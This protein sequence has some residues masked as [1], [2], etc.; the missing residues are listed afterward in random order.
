MEEPMNEATERFRTFLK[1]NGFYIVLV[2]CLLAIGV[3]IALIAIP[4]DREQ[5]ADATPDPEPVV[6]VGQSNDER[7]SEV[8]NKPKTTETPKLTPPPLAAITPIPTAEPTATPAARQNTASKAAPPVDGE[9]IFSYAVDK[10]IYSVTLDQWTTHPAIDIKAK[11]GTPVKC[12]FSGTVESVKKDDALGFSVRVQHANGRT[13]L[14][15]CL[16]EDVRVKEG[17]RVSAGDVIGTVG[18]S[19]ISE[20]A[21]PAH[22]HFAVLVDGKPKDP[23]KYIRLG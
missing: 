4:S 2:L 1:N 7:L 12:V 22:L 13:T 18:T 19:A 20:C 8:W 5:T 11:E 10:L 3:T 17:D 16:S 6:I 14:Y 9:I 23:Q 21:L 15:A